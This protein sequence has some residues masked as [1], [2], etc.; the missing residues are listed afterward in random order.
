MVGYWK[1]WT[2]NLSQRNS[3]QHNVMMRN[4]H[5]TSVSIRDLRSQKSWMTLAIF[6]NNRY[7]LWCGHADWD[8]LNLMASRA[9]WLQHTMPVNLWCVCAVH[10]STWTAGELAQEPWHHIT[11]QTW[12]TLQS[13]LHPTAVL[14][15]FWQIEKKNI[16]KGFAVYSL[17]TWSC[18]M[19]WG[20]NLLLPSYF[21]LLPDVQNAEAWKL[22]GWT[23]WFEL[24]MM[25]IWDTLK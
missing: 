16:A 25:Y 12:Q 22:K 6:L 15:N 9:E 10:S 19:L 5:N 4:P 20:A 8:L 11:F 14:H 17:Q 23:R 24:Y 21:M 13:Q 7:L 1:L 18:N 2:V 3:K